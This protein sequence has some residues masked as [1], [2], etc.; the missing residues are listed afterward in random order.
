MEIIKSV[1]EEIMTM[2][3]EGVLNTDTSV[4]LEMEIKKIGSEIKKLI[5]DFSG[6]EYISSAGLRVVLSAQKKMNKQGVM[7]VKNVNE[8]VMEVFAITGF[9]DI[10]VIE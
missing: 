10:L 7:I 2:V 3:V 4:Q 8:C 6:L 5:L 1:S 9:V